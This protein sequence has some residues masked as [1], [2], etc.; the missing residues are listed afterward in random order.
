ML[1]YIAVSLEKHLSRFLEIDL[2]LSEIDCVILKIQF[3]SLHE[4]DYRIVDV[5]VLKVKSSSQ[6]LP[7]RLLVKSVI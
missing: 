3:R 6:S 7:W 2:S 1:I 5:D 4:S